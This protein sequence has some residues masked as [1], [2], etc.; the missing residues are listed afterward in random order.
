MVKNQWPTTKAVMM[1]AYASTDT[2][3]K[4][5]RLGALDYVPKPFTPNELRKT[6]EAALE[7]KL[8]EAKISEEERKTVDP[9]DLDIPFDRDEVAK[10]AGEAYAD[11][12]GP[13]DMPVVEVKAPEALEN[14]CEV[15]DMVCEIFEKLGA[16]CKVGVKKSICPKLAKEKKGKAAKKS[17]GF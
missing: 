7:G 2:A 8:I 3:M 17:A 15:G 11:S 10:A 12:L 4:A 13:S 16:T 14:F 9:I 6:V 1:T 5:I